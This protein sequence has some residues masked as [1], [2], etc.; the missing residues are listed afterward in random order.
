[1]IDLE[2]LRKAVDNMTD[3]DIQK[4]FPKSNLPKGWVS[5]EEHLP[6]FLAKDI[7]QGGT[8]YQVKDK[9]GDEFKS[10]VSD[11]NVWYHW[12]KNN[13]ITHWSNE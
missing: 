11:H 5:I 7:R 1:M 3:E 9:W 10:L 13:D 2:K 8:L 6:K 4:Y 12:A